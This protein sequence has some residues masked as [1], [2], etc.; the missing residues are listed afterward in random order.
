MVYSMAVVSRQP[1]PSARVCVCMCVCA[2]VRVC[3]DTASLAGAGAS[4]W[5][6]VC[7]T[8]AT[9][10]KGARDQHTEATLCADALKAHS[11]LT[12]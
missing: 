3:G 7:L 10:H 6:H 9:L 2:R 5:L 8:P 12:H 4:L 1:L 11:V